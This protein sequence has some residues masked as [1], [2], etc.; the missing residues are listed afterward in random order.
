MGGITSR[1][2]ELSLWLGVNNNIEDVE[3]PQTNCLSI[4]SVE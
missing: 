2:V 3:R 1:K 4:S